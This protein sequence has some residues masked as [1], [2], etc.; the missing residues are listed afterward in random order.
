[1]LVL[2]CIGFLFDWGCI[3]RYILRDFNMFAL[4]V[5]QNVKVS[6]IFFYIKGLSVFIAYC[7]PGIRGINSYEHL[8]HSGFSYRMGCIAYSCHCHLSG[9]VF[10]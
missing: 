7:E 6:N 2:F 3:V 5:A 4:Y 1:M 10:M 8:C 9:M